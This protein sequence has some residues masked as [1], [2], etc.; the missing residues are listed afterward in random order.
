M[1]REGRVAP[2]DDSL[3]C[4]EYLATIKVLLNLGMRVHLMKRGKTCNGSKRRFQGPVRQSHL[5]L[6]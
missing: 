6:K 1:Q 4:T 5:W 3:K 2:H